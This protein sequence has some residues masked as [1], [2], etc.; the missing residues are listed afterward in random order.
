MGADFHE[1]TCRA[2]QDSGQC[3]CIELYGIGEPHPAC[4]MCGGSGL[5]PDCGIAPD[6]SRRNEP[7]DKN[8]PGVPK[9]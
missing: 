6:G 2:C 4:K 7:D 9:Q 5:C 3:A 1:M 8:D